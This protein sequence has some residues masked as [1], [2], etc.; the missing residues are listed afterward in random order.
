[1]GGGGENGCVP[2]I[3]LLSKCVSRLIKFHIQQSYK[4]RFVVLKLHDLM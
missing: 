4:G 1:M 2:I 3:V